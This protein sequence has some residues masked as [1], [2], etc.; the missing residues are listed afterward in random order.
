MAV[1]GPASAAPPANDDFEN[2]QTLTTGV[3]AAGSNVE[4]TAQSGEPVHSTWVS[5]NSSVWFTW[6]APATGLARV[7]S[8]GSDFDSVV[9]VY[10][11]STLSGLF[12]TRL[13]NNDNGCG[14]PTDA[15]VVYLRVQE[16]TTYRIVVDGW[17]ASDVG[18]YEL[19]AEVLGDPGAPPPNDDVD[20]A[21]TLAGETAT[22]TGTNVAA[23]SGWNEWPSRA[24]QLVWWRW[25]S[26]VDGQVRVDTCG[27]DFDTVLGVMRRESGEWAG[28]DIEHDGCGDRGMVSVNAVAGREYWIGV[29]GDL[30]AS[31]AVDL[32]IDATPDLTAP[33][34]T[35]SS[36]PSGEWG[37]R[38]A[39][40]SW[41]VEDEAATASECSIDDGPW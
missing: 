38:V 41:S 21:V 34:T 36:G 6:T 8:C 14:A 18:D 40:F 16:G 25:T 29:G 31:G 33:V 30:G 17:T 9:A 27:S 3:A 26:P 5:A 13:A 20:E 23:T 2:P 12:A 24:T 7:S 11:G 28:G 32:R 15:S 10:G 22:G 39:T 4:A 35:I 1:A 37:R 19:V